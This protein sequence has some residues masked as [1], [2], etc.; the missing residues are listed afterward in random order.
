ML[1][2]VQ[3]EKIRAYFYFSRIKTCSRFCSDFLFCFLMILPIY[4]FSLTA[5]VCNETESLSDYV[6]T[7]PLSLQSHILWRISKHLSRRYTP[8]PFPV[9]QHVRPKGVRLLLQRHDVLG[10]ALAQQQLLLPPPTGRL[11]GHQ[12]VRH[13]MR[14]RTDRDS[15]HT[16]TQTFFFKSSSEGLKV[17]TSEKPLRGRHREAL[18]ARSGCTAD[19]FSV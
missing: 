18:H 17:E 2:L 16:H 6:G 3:E 19:Y 15:C 8:L 7:G 5:L 4:C 10:D 1:I 11:P 13:V 12:A 9:P 14:P